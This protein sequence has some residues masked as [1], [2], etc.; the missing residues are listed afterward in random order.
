MAEFKEELVINALHTDKAEIGKK[1]WYADNIIE[2][3]RCV[4]RNDNTK[5]LVSIYRP[6]IKKWQIYNLLEAQREPIVDDYI[7]SEEVIAWC[8]LPK[9]KE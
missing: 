7:D 8:E 3:K 4:E 5:T 2:L 9:F 6:A 1:Y